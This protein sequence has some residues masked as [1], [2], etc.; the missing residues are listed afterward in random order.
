MSWRKVLALGLLGSAAF[1]GCTVTTGDGDDDSGVSTGGSTSTGGAKATGGS[2]AT[3]GATTTGGSTSTG[4]ADS[5]TFVCAPAAADND[6][7]KCVETKCCNEWL[8]CGR[9]AACSY[10]S[11]ATPGELICIQ[12]CIIDQVG[13][14]GTGVIDLPTCAA[15]CAVDVALSPATNDLI[16]CIRNVGDASVLQNCSTD[17]F[18]GE[19]TD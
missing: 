18:G 3:G 8:D 2:T 15:N 13:D 7:S 6:C 11:A 14:A 19:I 10:K 16:A 17:C 12:D 1:A 5:G 4:G 9:D